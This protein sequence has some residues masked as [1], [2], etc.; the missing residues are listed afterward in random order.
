M[1][2]FQTVQ[3]AL[4]QA[5]KILS[6]SHYVFLWFKPIHIALKCLLFFSSWRQDALHYSEIIVVFLG[7]QTLPL[8]ALLCLSWYCYFI[9]C[10]QIWSLVQLIP[11]PSTFAWNKKHFYSQSP[12][13]S[14]TSRWSF[15]NS[16]HWNAQIFAVLQNKPACYSTLLGFFVV[17]Q[18]CYSILTLIQFC[19]PKRPA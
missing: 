6:Q 2:N 8:W 13:W 14:G 12:H 16:C 19:F 7:S 1:Q 10:S 3:Q 5:W 15:C 18:N 9:F 17:F 4:T 11:I